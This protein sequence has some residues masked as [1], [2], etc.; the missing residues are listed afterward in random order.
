[1]QAASFIRS[2]QLGRYLGLFVFF[3]MR[4]AVGTLGPA[5][6]MTGRVLFAALFLGLMG[7]LL[8]K[9]STGFKK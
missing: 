3:F 5:A 9:A 2:V 4:I 6:L 7:W 8:E 1:M